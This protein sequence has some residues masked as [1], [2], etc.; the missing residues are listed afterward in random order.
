M[1]NGAARCAIGHGDLVPQEPREPGL[2]GKLA[3]HLHPGRAGG[4]C[5]RHRTPAHGAP[6]AASEVPGD[7]VG[8]ALLLAGVVSCAGEGKRGCMLRRG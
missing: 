7:T 8:T 5:V 3:A 2:G 4:A 1:W 6:A